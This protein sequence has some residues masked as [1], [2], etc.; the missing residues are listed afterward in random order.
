MF[1]ISASAPIGAR[2]IAP[3]LM[4]WLQGA[5]HIKSMLLDWEAVNNV[6]FP[7]HV[8]HLLEVASSSMATCMFLAVGWG[9]QFPP[10][11]LR[12][13]PATRNRTRDHLIAAEIYSQMLYQLS[14]S[15]SCTHHVPGILPMSATR[16]NAF[17]TRFE[18]RN[19]EQP[20]IGFEPTTTRLEAFNDFD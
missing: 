2:L 9:Q 7:R 18:Q 6:T 17:W 8:S 5:C 20:T 4:H 10:S 19:I 11:A 16:S 15:R 3:G 13:Y 14:Y 12:I 1:V